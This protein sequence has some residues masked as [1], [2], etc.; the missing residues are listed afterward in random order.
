MFCVFTF[1]LIARPQDY[2]PALQPF[3]LSMLFTILASVVTVLSRSGS[4]SL[5][6][7]LRHRETKAYLFFFAVL[8]AGIPFSLYRRASFEFVLMRYVV[9]LIFFLLFV[10]HVNTP[11]RY[12]QIA[13]VLGVSAFLFSLVGLLGGE[14]QSG[15]FRTLSTMFDSND[16]A[17][18]ELSL[19]P[20]SLF[21]LLGPYRLITRMMA[22]GGVLMGVVLTLFTGSRGGLLGL[23][24]SVLLFLVL[25][26]TGV[27][28]GRKLV[29]LA[30]IAVV[31]I[32][33]ADQ[34]NMERYTTLGSLEQDYNVTSETG[35]AQ[36]WSRGFQLFLEQP[37]LGV[38]ASRFGEALAAMRKEEHLPPEWQTAHN[39]YLEVLTET[40]TFGAA[41]F[42][43]LILTSLSTFNRL[44]RKAQLSPESLQGLAVLPGVLLIGCV[45]Q[46]VAATFLSLAYSVAFPLLFA[47]SAA[48]KTIAEPPPPDPRIHA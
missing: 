47:A 12:K 19:L 37:F 35:R 28:R 42:L 5:G 24:I 43:C 20:F 48:L 34:I 3:R 14:F 46:L 31:A 39:S 44:R 36:I 7:I 45:G 4:G 17:F 26:I 9:N 10:T 22:L 11:R 40:G 23:S 2:L 8:C 21:I 41:A 15:R 32:T 33:N 27:S 1:V 6:S 25:R 16:V 18:V 13:L 30:F 38:G 29:M